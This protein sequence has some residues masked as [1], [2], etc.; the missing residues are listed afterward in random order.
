MYS[1]LLSATSAVDLETDKSIQEIIRGPQF[2]NTTI[3][4]IA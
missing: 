1:P 3:L 2:K 4:T